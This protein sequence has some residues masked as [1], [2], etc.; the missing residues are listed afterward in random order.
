MKHKVTKQQENRDD[1]TYTHTKNRILHKQQ[2]DRDD[3]EYTN[4]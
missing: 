4:S 3:T 1:T 2:E